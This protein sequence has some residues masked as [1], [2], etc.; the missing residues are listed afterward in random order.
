MPPES[1]TD[2]KPKEDFEGYT[3]NAGMTL[4]RWYRHAAVALWP[5]AR[6]EDVLCAGGSPNAVPAL[7][8]MVKSWEKAQGQ[9]ARTL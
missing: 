4:E 5:R 2:V 8:Q 3:G 9:D 1:L 7:R 6:H